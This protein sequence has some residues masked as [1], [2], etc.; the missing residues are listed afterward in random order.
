MD[1]KHLSPTARAEAEAQRA[2]LAESPGR[3]EFFKTRGEDG[4][5]LTPQQLEEAGWAYIYH[6]ETGLRSVVNMN[7]LRFKL[8]HRNEFGEYIW[9]ASPPGVEPRRGQYKC[10]LHP[11]DPNRDNYDALGFNRCGKENLTSPFQVRRH[12]QKRHKMEWD[13]I[14]Q[15]RKDAERAEERAE[16]AEDRETQRALMEKIAGTK[17]IEAEE[18][19][20]TPEAP[21]YVSDKDKKK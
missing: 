21:L 1:D 2:G 3:Q 20:G 19:L 18:T 5:T 4:S 16:R 12:M 10:M 14:D 8:G 13:A 17:T 9:S 11:D 6:V 7:W 15:I